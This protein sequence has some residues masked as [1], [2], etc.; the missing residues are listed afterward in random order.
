M[1]SP[2]RAH[3]GLDYIEFVVIDM[4]AT[5]Q[6]YTDAFGWSFNG[7]GPDYAGIVIAGREVGGFR[8]DVPLTNGGP[9]VVIYSTDLDATLAGIRGAGG[10]VLQEPYEFPGGR[11]FH[12]AD[13]SGN[14]LA[15]W[16]E[17]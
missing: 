1:T 13:P 3:H 4:D 5:Q 17:K 7:Y 16:S 6:F 12:F 10:R 2:G 11:R 15:V 8:S 14:E 9:L